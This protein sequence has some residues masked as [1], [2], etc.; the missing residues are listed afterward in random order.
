M[1]PGRWA[2]EDLI[3]NGGTHTVTIPK[4]IQSGDYLLRYE[5]LALHSVYSK[6]GAQ[7][8]TGYAQITVTGGTNS[9]TPSTVSIPG[10]YAQN[11]PGILV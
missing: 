7:F 11:D 4:C 9:K 2:V 3:A 10:V 6:M 5:L 1:F 8:Y